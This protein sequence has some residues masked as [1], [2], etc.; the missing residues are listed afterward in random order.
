MRGPG[1]GDGGARTRGGPRPRSCEERRRRTAPAQPGCAGALRAL[2]LRPR[3]A[4]H[5]S[6]RTAP[7]LT[8][9]G[10]CAHIWAQAPSPPPARPPQGRWRRR[11]RRGAAPHPSTMRNLR[12]LRTGGRRCAAALGTPQCFCLGAEPGT[13]LVGSQQGLVELGPAGDSVR[14][15]AGRTGSRALASL[16]GLGRGCGCGGG[17]RCPSAPAHR[18]R[19]VG[20][21]FGPPAAKLEERPWASAGGS[22]P[23]GGPRLPSAVARSVMRRSWGLKSL[24]LRLAAAETA[25]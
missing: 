17:C 13:V 16:S 18:C 9:E 7:A 3:P 25:L 22:G 1:A 14:A 8:A 20:G 10:A 4:A 2:R 15:A 11:E 6:L 24:L 12:L 23:L 19:R 5:A 21:G